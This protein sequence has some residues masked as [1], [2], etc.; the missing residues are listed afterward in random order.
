[1]HAQQK[2][3]FS[4]Y[5][6]FTVDGFEE[7]LVFSL[8][9]CNNSNRKCMLSQYTEVATLLAVL[10]QKQ[11]SLGCCQ[12]VIVLY[13]EKS[14]HT[15]TGWRI[16]FVCHSN[17][18][19]MESN[20]HR[21]PC[22]NTASVVGVGNKTRHIHR[23]SICSLYFHTT[24]WCCCAVDTVEQ[25]SLSIALSWLCPSQHKASGVGNHVKVFWLSWRS[26]V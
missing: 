26:C 13:R 24:V 6:A 20:A 11:L 25:D 16:T 2:M 8:F 5:I 22:W 12:I 21:V 10:Q 23:G 1:M 14:K 17:D 19:L 4:V 9:S 7:S 15:V 3:N 18:T